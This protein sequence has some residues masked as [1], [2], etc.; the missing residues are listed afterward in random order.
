MYHSHYRG[1]VSFQ[2]PSYYHFRTKEPDG[3]YKK[4]LMI[5]VVPIQAGKSRVIFR[6]AGPKWLPTWLAHAGA[7]RFLNT[8]IWLHAVERR[9]RSKGQDV[10]VND[11]YI[12]ASSSDLGVKAFRK[13]RVERYN[14]G[15]VLFQSGRVEEHVFDYTSFSH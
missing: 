7:N 12:M 15:L 4:R 10:D 11:L 9:L 3:E 8:D 6:N 2:R 1:V 5:Y 14:N 13:V